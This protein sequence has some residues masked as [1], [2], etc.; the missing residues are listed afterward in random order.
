MLLP[1]SLVLESGHCLWESR[2]DSWSRK[3]CSHF[4][5]YRNVFSRLNCYCNSVANTLIQSPRLRQA[6][7][8]EHYMSVIKKRYSAIPCIVRVEHC[9]T[10]Y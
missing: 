4:F 7:N 5:V 9:A 2:L 10:L 3:T 1:E 6:T 8:A